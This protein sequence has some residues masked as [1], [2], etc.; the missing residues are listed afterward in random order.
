MH[1]GDVADQVEVAQEDRAD[2]TV[3][4]AAGHETV[5]HC[6]SPR[7]G[8]PVDSLPIDRPGANVRISG[9]R[10]ERCTWFV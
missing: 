3:E 6:R 8:G 9:Y 2:Q 1:E 5:L 10:M 7:T 4:V